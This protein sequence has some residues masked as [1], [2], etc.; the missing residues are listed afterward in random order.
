MTVN[1]K[2][3]VYKT[4]VLL[5]GEEAQSSQEESYLWRHGS[6]R[7]DSKR[8]DKPRPLAPLYELQVS[9]LRTRMTFTFL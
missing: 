8:L 3:I 5:T 2:R 7:R 9:Y 6:R 1:V 4:E